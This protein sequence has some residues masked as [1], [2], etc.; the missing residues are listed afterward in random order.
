MS[1]SIYAAILAAVRVTRAFIA[2]GNRGERFLNVARVV[3]AHSLGRLDSE[4]VRFAA[5]GQR[6]NG[7][8][9][10]LSHAA[11]Y[12][13]SVPSGTFTANEV[14]K[15]VVKVSGLI[16]RET[17]L[18]DVNTKEWEDYKRVKAAIEN[19]EATEK[20]AQAADLARLGGLTE[21]DLVAEAERLAEEL[22]EVTE[23]LA[24]RLAWAVAPTGRTS[25]YLAAVRT[26]PRPDFSG[27]RFS[28]EGRRHA[29]RD[30]AVGEWHK[31]E[32]LRQH[33]PEVFLVRWQSH[34]NQGIVPQAGI[35]MSAEEWEY[36]AED[37]G[38]PI[39]VEGGHRYD[40]SWPG[41]NDPAPAGYTSVNGSFCRSGIAGPIW[42]SH[43]IAWLR[44]LTAVEYEAWVEATCRQI[45]ARVYGSLWDA[46][47]W[48]EYPQV[49]RF[50]GVAVHAILVEYFA[51]GTAERELPSTEPRRRR[52]KTQADS[53]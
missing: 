29:H 43:P 27:E 32:L 28:G 36:A 18:P 23:P 46:R 40:W 30:M 13:L 35:Y 48:G 4:C 19:G 16:V 39:D 1:M 25:E 50:D 53:E 8:E 49:D 44:R 38:L 37:R 9:W 3:L 45:E 51:S 2:A 11:M 31:T 34:R 12:L 14:L 52:R 5:V 22:G 21:A 10:Y 24:T 41:V 33:R 7:A 15:E 20:A 42:S 6:G 26:I 17:Q 47:A